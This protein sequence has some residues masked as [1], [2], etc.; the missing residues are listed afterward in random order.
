MT[1]QSLECQSAFGPWTAVLTP[2]EGVIALERE[3][4][5]CATVVARPG[6]LAALNARM[7]ARFRI[8]L[9][10][11]PRRTGTEAIALVGWGPDTWLAT[12]GE[13]TNTD[14]AT[15]REAV[16]DLAAVADQSG[17]YSALRL[18]G[19]CVRKTLAKL[20]PID[21]HPCAFKVA[22]AASTVA[23]H[24]PLLIWRLA[25]GAGGD[26]VFE[27]CVPRSLTRSFQHALAASAAEFGLSAGPCGGPAPAEI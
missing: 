19:P 9:P 11:G 12:A 14:A 13:T 18:T 7:Q 17:A 3:H 1:I 15:L 5:I 4:S 2:G 22:D 23:A 10:D 8:G 27:L 16:G 21:L 26:A 25:D 24:I 6:N 20:L